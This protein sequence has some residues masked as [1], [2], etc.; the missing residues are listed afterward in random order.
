MK[1]YLMP[2]VVVV[3]LVSSSFAFAQ[4]PKTKKE[5]EA[6]Q[7]IQ[8]ATDDDARIAAIENLLTKFADTEYKIVVLEAAMDSARHKGDLDTTDLYGE[9]LLEADPNNLNALSTLAKDIADRTREFDLDRN[10]KLKR[11]DDL[12]NKAIKVGATAAKPS[13]QMTDEQWTQRKGFYM[14][15]SHAA[16]G[17]AALIEKKS[18]VAIKEYGAALEI[19]NDP[20]TS[21]RL[22]MANTAAG[23]FDAAIVILDKLLA[24]SDLD[25]RIKQVAGQEKV[26]AAMAKAKAK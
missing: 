23:K 6:L 11:V 9:R 14:A 7:A 20:S 2:A 1:Q 5:I 17:S 26:K 8:A 25:P 10:D 12:A 15:D 3:A 21:V 18:E 4:K 13:A 16:L 22:A 19:V 24:I